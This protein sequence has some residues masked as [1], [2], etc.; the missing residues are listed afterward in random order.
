MTNVDFSFYPLFGLSFLWSPALIVF[1]GLQ[2]LSN[3]LMIAMFLLTFLDVFSSF[4]SFWI[5][6]CL[7]AEA[8]WSCWRSVLT[9]R[10]VDGFCVL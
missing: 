9:F 2:Q 5:S 7:I 1:C 4:S 8:S 6:F 10:A 3:D